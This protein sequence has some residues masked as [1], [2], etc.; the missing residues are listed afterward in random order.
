MSRETPRTIWQLQLVSLTSRWAPG[1]DQGLAQCTH[2]HF[3]PNTH[4]FLETYLPFPVGYPESLNSD[5]M[6]SCCLKSY[7]LFTFL[8]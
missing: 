8:E 4:L 6:S 1:I 7:V 3:W 2:S 5:I